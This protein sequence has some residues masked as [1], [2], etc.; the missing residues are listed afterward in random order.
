MGQGAPSEVSA[1]D[2]LLRIVEPPLRYLSTAHPRRLAPNAL[3]M[4]RILELIDRAAAEAK[5]DRDALGRLRAILVDFPLDAEEARQRRAEEG[6]REVERLKHPPAPLPALLY[7]A[8]EGDVAAMLALLSAPAQ[9]LK[10]VGPKRA[11]EL[12]RFGIATVEDVLYHLPF[13]YEDRRSLT[14][15]RAARAGTAGHGGA[16]IIAAGTSYAGRRRR[17]ILEAKASDGGAGADAHLVSPDRVLRAEAQSRHANGAARQARE[18]YGR[19]QM[20]HPEVEV[21]EGAEDELG[22]IVPIYEKPT[23][24]SVGAMRKIVHAARAEIGE[25]LPSVLLA[26]RR[27]ASA[28]D[29]ATAFAGSTSPAARR[30]RR[31]STNGARRLIARSSST[32]SSSSGSA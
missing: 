24:M 31:R 25:R 11:A 1:V 22:R 21:L 32:S 8:S 17:R 5:A 27:R 20:I 9:F 10:G 7:A 6:L 3:P 28:V 19:R 4:K 16:E 18:G 2:E 23:E 29:L 26:G 13:R 15:D 30:R 12:A 14:P